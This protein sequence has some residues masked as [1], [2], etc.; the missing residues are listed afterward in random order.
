L[1]VENDGVLV[2][3][4]LQ[5]LSRERAAERHRSTTLTRRRTV[6]ELL[7]GA[8][9]ASDERR[10]TAT[11]KRPGTI[12]EERARPRRPGPSASTSSWAR[13]MRS[14]GEPRA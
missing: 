2:N 1:I 6:A 12:S 3:E 11:E 7:R 9:K 10:R 13:R 5:R 4:L 14:G 8:E